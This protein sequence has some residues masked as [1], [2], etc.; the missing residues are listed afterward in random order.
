MKKQYKRV[1]KL[2]KL[3][4]SMVQQA[5]L[6]MVTRCLGQIVEKV[7]ELQYDDREPWITCTASIDDNGAVRWEPTRQSLSALFLEAIAQ[8]L[9]S[10][11]AS[12]EK[13]VNNPLFAKYRLAEGGEVKGEE[14][15]R[16]SFKAM[17]EESPQYLP[18]LGEIEGTLESEF[19]ATGAQE[20]V[21]QRFIEIYVRH[22]GLASM[23]NIF[24]EN[25]GVE[26]CN[27]VEQWK[28]DEKEMAGLVEEKR[29]RLLLYNYAELRR[30]IV[31]APKQTLSAFFALLP[32][33][34]ALRCRNLML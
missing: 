33:E 8:H 13:I 16:S 19:E 28:R 23:A 4:D 6:E 15:G 29:G 22:R 27:F 34:T 30:N 26:L 21:L 18:L 32:D 7:K 25:N 31:G 9:V 17:V 12:N 5:K 3:A 20:E 10:L 1:Y 11:N 14:D 24:R 2:I